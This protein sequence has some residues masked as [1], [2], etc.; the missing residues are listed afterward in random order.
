MVD[1]NDDTYD[2]IIPDTEKAM[3]ADI[4]M[5]MVLGG[6]M[7]FHP[8]FLLLSHLFSGIAQTV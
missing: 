7:V 2:I 6:L 4:R 5:S 8:Y 1:S 3:N